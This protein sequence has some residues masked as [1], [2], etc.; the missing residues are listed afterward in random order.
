MQTKNKVETKNQNTSLHPSL[1]LHT[2]AIIFMTHN[3]TS[4]EQQNFTGVLMITE[5]VPK[6]LLPRTVCFLSVDAGSVHLMKHF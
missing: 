6:V 3:T 2:I 4:S 5:Y 1:G